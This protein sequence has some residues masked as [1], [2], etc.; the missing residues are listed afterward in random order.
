MADECAPGR[1]PPPE[2]AAPAP[3]PAGGPAGRRRP[4]HR[5]TAGGHA[6]VLAELSALA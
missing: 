6:V 5:G 1:H 4:L 3:F 2:P